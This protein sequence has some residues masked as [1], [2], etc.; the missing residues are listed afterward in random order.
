M[1]N[2]YKSFNWVTDVQNRT[3]CEPSSTKKDKVDST[4]SKFITLFKAKHSG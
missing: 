2:V 4:L 3:I 1:P